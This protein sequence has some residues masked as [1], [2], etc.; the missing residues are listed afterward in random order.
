M[1]QREELGKN[2]LISQKMSYVLG[3]EIISYS[4]KIKGVRELFLS[5][6]C[7]P[8]RFYGAYYPVS[9]SFHL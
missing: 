4:G 3:Y 6:L 7:W 5:R 1:A 9:L 2:I 8:V